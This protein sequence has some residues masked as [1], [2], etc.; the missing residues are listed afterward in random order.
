MTVGLDSAF[1]LSG[2]AG[3]VRPSGAEHPPA[4]ARD[5]QSLSYQRPDSFADRSRGHAVVLGQSR[6]GR[7]RLPMLPLARFDPVPEVFGHSLVRQLVLAVH[8]EMI[9]PVPL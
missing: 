2:M 4:L 7:Q 1:C 9:F 8:T 5:N 3:S 6:H